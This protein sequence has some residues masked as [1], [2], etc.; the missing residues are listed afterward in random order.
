MRF[1]QFNTINEGW[2]DQHYN[3]RLAKFTKNQEKEKERHQAWAR[4]NYSSYTGNMVQSMSKE[5]TEYLLKI[6]GHDAPLL[7]FTT[8][9][10]WKNWMIKVVSQVFSHTKDTKDTNPSP[11]FYIRHLKDYF[12]PL[13]DNFAKHAASGANNNGIPQN[14]D[15]YVSAIGQK[16]AEIS[17]NELD[18]MRKKDNEIDQMTLGALTRGVVVPIPGAKPSPVTPSPL[19]EPPVTA[20]IEPIT[21]GGE[22]WTKGPKGWINTKGRAATSNDAALLDKA[23]AASQNINAQPQ[24]QPTGVDRRKTGLD[25]SLVNTITQL[26]AKQRSQ[27]LT[28]LKKDLGII[29]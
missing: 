3:K 28:E 11:D 7:H 12:D 5:M 19:P 9:S 15:A 18:A 17:I 16:I 21:L 29:K 2:F 8:E 10:Q 24:L 26:T 22:K 1:N 6:L 20:D 25:E 23:L 4:A 14:I 27:L 13:I